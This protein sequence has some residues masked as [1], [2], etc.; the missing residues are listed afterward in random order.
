MENNIFGYKA[1]YRDEEGLYCKLIND[2]KKYRY[3]EGGIYEVEGPLELCENGIHFCRY[4]NT[5]FDWYPLTQWIEV[6]RVE[7]L[8]KIEDQMY[9]DK[10]CTNKLKVLEKIPYEDLIQQFKNLENFKYYVHD[11]EKADNEEKIIDSEGIL[12]SNFIKKDLHIK[13]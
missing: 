1:F 10:S 2:S 7:I 9:Y 3:E 11:F 13:N 8:G 4:L 6:H 12:N 5:L